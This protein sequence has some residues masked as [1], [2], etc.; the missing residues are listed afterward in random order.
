M[1]LALPLVRSASVE[2][3]WPRIRALNLDP[4]LL[5]IM[6]IVA[7]V[8][9]PSMGAYFHGDDFV[10]MTD[11]VS[12]PPLRH[13]ADVYTFGDADFYWRPLGKTYDVFIYQLFG[14]SPVAFHIGSVLF[15]EGTIVMLYWLTRR[16][17][18]PQPVAVAA[19]L[20]F[21]LFPN[22]VVSV[23]WITNT[24]RLMAVF[25]FVA[26]MLMIEQ[27]AR[28]KRF[29]D[30]AAAWLLFLAAA[31]SDETSLALAPL[32]ILFSIL[33]RTK[34]EHWT[35]LAARALAFGGMA[36]ALVPLQFMYTRD[37][38]P[39]LATY[40][41]GSHIIDQT[42][43]LS[44]QL[45]L[46]IKGGPPMS[47]AFA[48]LDALQ[49]A[50]GALTILAAAVLLLV[51]SSRMRF[52]VIWGGLALAPFTLWAVPYTAPR[53]VYMTAVPFAIVVA[54]LAYAAWQALAPK[55]ST[56]RLRLVPVAVA[57]T[58]LV[59]LGSF[60]NIERN[61]TWQ[62]ATDP[63]RVLATGLKQSLPTVPPHS[64][65][66]IYYGVWDGFNAWPNAV[67]R[68]IYKDPTLDAINVPAKASEDS[69]QP[70]RANDI[71]VFYADGHFI[72][73]PYSA[74]SAH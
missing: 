10:A 22:H 31:L 2:R 64:R 50:A 30:E 5:L 59:V 43:A 8:H 38:E 4:Y 60:A 32:P 58:A 68:T 12:K 48:S 53:Y 67:V 71:V 37:D 6:A 34:R 33:V 16:M 27:A 62:K 70:R 63:Y 28:T 73:V 51:G 19:C 56:A 57:A 46:P 66:I 18:M 29:P 3:V 21:A 45:V 11:L 74:A 1:T 23:A 65:L 14:L 41:F 26:S 55:L 17:G 24:S 13:L 47:E 54:W 40:T 52:L 25:F 61:D 42:W 36:A 39:R 15:F 7:A 72:S 35:S 9:I 44:S 69:N 49:W 20:I